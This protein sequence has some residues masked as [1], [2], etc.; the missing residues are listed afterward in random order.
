[1][2]A[3]G[4]LISQV[5]EHDGVMSSLAGGDCASSVLVAPLEDRAA[6]LWLLVVDAIIC[7]GSLRHFSPLMPPSNQYWNALEPW[8]RAKLLYVCD[9][10]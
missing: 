4:A 10:S 3:D 1:M 5:R 9:L 8:F 2:D 7:P 6:E